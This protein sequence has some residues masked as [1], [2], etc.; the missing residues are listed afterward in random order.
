MVME[1]SVP[2]T[3]MDDN[4]R[5]LDTKC[6]YWINL[7]MELWLNIFKLLP[8]TT[9]IFVVRHVC[10]YF[11]QLAFDPILWKAIDM[12][13]WKA[14]TTAELLTKNTNFAQ[15][16]YNDDLNTILDSLSLNEEQTSSKIFIAI[17]KSIYHILSKVTF[18]RYENDFLF[19]LE[20]QYALFKCSNLL[21]FDASFCN[22]ITSN[23]LKALSSNCVK[24]KTV[25]LEGCR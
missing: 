23:T 3:L 24:L 19:G 16:A 11:R 20:E 6:F 8:Q 12:N 17:A 18:S 13:S 5:K 9:L 2:L 14:T 21:Y 15:P 25:I 1:T 22:E 7:P 10:K 4:E